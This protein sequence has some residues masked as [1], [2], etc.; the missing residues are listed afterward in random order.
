[1]PPGPQKPNAPVTPADFVEA[2]EMVVRSRG[3]EVN[4]EQLDEILEDILTTSPGLS[5]SGGHDTSSSSS[6]LLDAFTPAQLATTVKNLAVVCEEVRVDFVE[7]LV[8]QLQRRLGEFSAQQL[9]AVGWGL[10]RLLPV[11]HEE[12]RVGLGMDQQWL[13]SYVAAAEQQLQQVL[14]PPPSP[15]QQEEQTSQQQQEQQQEVALPVSRLPSAQQ[16]A[17]LLLLPAAALLPLQPSLL[18]VLEE[19]LLLRQASLCGYAVAQLLT[20]YVRWVRR[21]L[22]GA[23][24]FVGGG[25]VRACVECVLAQGAAGGLGGHNGAWLQARLASTYQCLSQVPSCLRCV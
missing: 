13:D 1:M 16:V 18:G 4:A 25:G 15:P 21:G 23:G 3:Q 22:G 12:V 20:C 10:M 7:A 6:S 17:N 5:D 19:V 9:A 8:R 14:Q 24:A 2:L 11:A